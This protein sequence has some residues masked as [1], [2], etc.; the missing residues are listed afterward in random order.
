M[1]GCQCF[2]CV[3]PNTVDENSYVKFPMY[4]RTIIG[5]YTVTAVMQNATPTIRF[6][7]KHITHSFGEATNYAHRMLEM[8][9][10]R[11][12]G[13]NEAWMWTTHIMGLGAVPMAMIDMNRILSSGGSAT[14]TMPSCTDFTFIRPEDLR[15]LTLNKVDAWYRIILSRYRPKIER[16][17]AAS[18]DADA[19]TAS[20]SALSVGKRRKRGK[21]TE[22]GVKNAPAAKKVAQDD[23]YVLTD[24]EDEKLPLC[25]WDINADTQEWSARN[26]GDFLTQFPARAPLLIGIDE[27]IKPVSFG[28]TRVTARFLHPITRVIVRVQH[29]STVSVYQVPQY[30]D[31]LREAET[32]FGAK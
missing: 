13:T 10:K 19:V 6:V 20:S 23:K 25:V 7:N 18:A 5:P 32:I 2:Y 15:N 17:A 12:Q 27:L 26:V 4:I 31:K 30:R 3:C 8:S 29:L 9:C 11:R 21:A 28:S 1:S 16:P 24:S 22:N 14:G